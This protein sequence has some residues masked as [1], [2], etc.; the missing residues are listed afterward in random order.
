MTDLLLTL[1][2]ASERAARVARACCLGSNSETLLIAEKFDGDANIRFERD[3]KTI[4]D[5]LA[6]ESAKT[7][8]ASRFPSLA[9]HVRGEECSEMGGV[10]IAVQDSV[11]KTVE[12]LSYLVTLEPAQRMA[13][14]VHEDM[15]SE[16]TDKLPKNLPNID[17][18]DLGVWIDPIGMKS[19]INHLSVYNIKFCL[20][21][22]H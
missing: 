7:E 2:K 8:I 14:A 21:A 19:Y 12:L 16:Y 11:E 22:N 10:R 4:A 9:E 15:S 18:S 1:V 5:V 17:I 3:F 6:Q 13:A 20:T